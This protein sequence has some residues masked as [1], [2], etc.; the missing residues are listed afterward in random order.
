MAKKSSFW[1]DFKSFISKGNVL[2]M[3]VGVVIGGAFGKIVT[4]LVN[5]IINPIIGL[6][7]GGTSLDL[8]K[9]VIKPA[10]VVDGVEVAEVAILW[11]SWFQT[12]LDFVIVALCIFCVL[13]AIMKAK[14]IVK[15]KELAENEKKAAEE[16]AKAEEEKKAAE[17]AAAALEAKKVA[18]ED[19]TLR[20]EKLLEEIKELLAKK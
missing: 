5:F 3:A 13:R 1:S 11:G 6:L 16:K 14:N 2:D 7:T 15:A 20:S 9:T 19:A 8:L 17:E 4:G 12:I 18:V 10:A